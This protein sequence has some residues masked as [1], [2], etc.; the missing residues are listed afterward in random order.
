[1]VGEQIQPDQAAVAFDAAF[2][3]GVANLVVGPG[4]TSEL[5]DHARDLG[6]ERV[7]L[8]S[9][10]RVVES[11]APGTALESL[12]SAGIEADLFVDVAIEPTDGSFA[13]AAEAAGAARYDGFVAVGGG[14]VMDTAK[15]ANLYSTYPA[16][17]LAYVNPPIGN[18]VPP[19]GPLR[20][21][22]AI[23]TTA[24]TGSETTGVA[25]FDLESM[26]AKTGIS[27]RLLRPS[28]AIIDP[29]NTLSLP[30]MVTASCAFDILSHALEAYTARPSTT[31]PRPATPGARPAYQ[32]SN[33]FSDIW[34]ERTLSMLPVALRHVIANPSDVAARTELALAATWAG[35][36][37]GNAGVHLPHGMSYAVSGGVKEFVAPDYPRNRPLVPHG[38]SVVLNAP[39]VF[40]HT[41]AASPGRH[42][43]AAELLGASVDGVPSPEFW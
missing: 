33:P 8:F 30:P 35:I 17:F 42:L 27:H 10:P 28:L 23:P 26:H 20:P 22:I 36:G 39:S 24:G 34:A 11:G 31:R 6:L 9:D 29:L 13:Q 25:I 2:S 43:R 19:P 5:G 12:R 1:M 7:L 37:F 38:M 14:S 3:V 40:R 18:G 16:D 32:G 21:L 15:A 41:A 4:A